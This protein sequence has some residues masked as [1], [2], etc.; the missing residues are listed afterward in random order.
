[1][2]RDR[3]P[4][5]IDHLILEGRKIA[6]A[7]FAYFGTQ[8]VVDRRQLAPAAERRLVSRTTRFTASIATAIGW[9]ITQKARRSGSRHPWDFPA[10]E[11]TSEFEWAQSDRSVRTSRELAEI[12]SNGDRFVERVRRIASAE[13]VADDLTRKGFPSKTPNGPK[14]L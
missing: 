9:L 12:L 10:I 8:L 11:G 3:G 4:D 7:A 14:E 13:R 2:K 5:Q 1:M 6:E